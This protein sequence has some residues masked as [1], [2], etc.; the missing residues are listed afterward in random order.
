MRLNTGSTFSAHCYLGTTVPVFGEVVVS[1][2]DWILPLEELINKFT[3]ISYQLLSETAGHKK[4]LKGQCIV[5]IF[6]K[7]EQAAITRF[8]F[9]QIC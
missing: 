4:R 8:P 2:L 6:R 1:T 3:V 9:A 7:V 5:A